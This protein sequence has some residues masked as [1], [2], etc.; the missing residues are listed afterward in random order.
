MLRRHSEEDWYEDCCAVTC[1]A[2]NVFRCLCKLPI[3][4]T[5]RVEDLEHELYM[6]H[7]F[8]PVTLFRMSLPACYDDDQGGFET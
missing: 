7:L 2:G 4:S 6:T 3:F 5:L 8:L 1:F